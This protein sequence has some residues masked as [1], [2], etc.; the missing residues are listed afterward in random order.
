M[1]HPLDQNAGVAR[2][3]LDAIK[4]DR[5]EDGDARQ[6]CTYYVAETRNSSDKRSTPRRRTRLR[7]GK[8]LD[9]RNAFLIECQIFDRSEKGARIR[10]VEDIWAPGNIRLFEDAPQT[11]IDAIVVWRKDRE[12]GLC[13]NPCAQSRGITK[14]QLACLRGRYYAV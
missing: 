13:F 12:I 1:P 5:P 8:V 11:L 14:A 4:V 10:L 2:A 3:M 6:N 9:H 7:S